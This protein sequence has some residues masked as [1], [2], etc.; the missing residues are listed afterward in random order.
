MNLLVKKIGLVLLPA[1]F[2]ACEDPTELGAN[3]NPNTGA[4]ST[5]YIELPVNTSQVRSDSTLTSL[6]FSGNSIGNY[7][8]IGRLDNPDFGVTKATL[9]ANLGLPTGLPTI[10]NNA[11][12]DSVRIQLVWNSRNVFGTALRQEQRFQTYRLA[13]PISPTNSIVENDTVNVLF[14]R[15]YAINKEPLGEP[16]GQLSLDISEVYDKLDSATFVSD[17]SRRIMAGQL[18]YAFGEQ[19][20]AALRSNTDGIRDSQAAFDNFVKGIAL[21]PEDINTFV[22]TYELA[23]ANSG[24]FLYYTQGTEQR[25]LRLPFYP[26]ETNKVRYGYQTSLNTLPA[27]YGV[28]VDRSGTGLAN[29]S[30][31]GHLQEFNPLDGRVYFQGLGGLLPKVEFR[32]FKD[33][34]LNQDEGD[35]ISINRASLEFDSLFNGVTRQPIPNE[36]VLYFVNDNNRRFQSAMLSGAERAPS[37]ARRFYTVGETN[38]N[39]FT[40][41]IVY[42][43]EQYMKTGEDRYLQAML[44]PAES[45]YNS[46]NQFVIKPGQVKLKIWYT[47]LARPNL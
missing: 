27:Y 25:T 4:V 19:I 1:L 26:S 37:T 29:A 44:Y 9:Y 15:Y 6:Q 13:Q 36:A 20:L 31:A 40:S 39:Y 22:T 38:V 47:K 5:H 10:G 8:Y 11:R 3:L 21:V 24:V 12:L 34:I 28:E 18:D 7:P 35:L 45:V 23:N 30:S 16:L 14:Y 32:V 17:A 43:L 46:P 2:F 42:N 41:D 33:F